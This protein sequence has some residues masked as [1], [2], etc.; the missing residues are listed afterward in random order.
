MNSKDSIMMLFKNPE[1][2]KEAE[3]YQT[4]EDFQKG[5]A[6]YGLELTEQEVVDFCADAAKYGENKELAVEELEE[7]AGGLGPMFWLGVGCV[8]AAAIGAYNGY[9]GS[10]KK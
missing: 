1:F 8:V 7:V 4:I 3:G 6:K 10:R 2:V 9:V 5:F